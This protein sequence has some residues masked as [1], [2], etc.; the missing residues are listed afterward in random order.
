MPADRVEGV[1]VT[2]TAFDGTDDEIRTSIGACNILGAFT[3]GAVVRKSADG[4][5][6]A[7][8]GNHDAA[9][10]AQC[11]LELRN[12]NV[13][14][15]NA[16]GVG[17]FSTTTILIADGWVRLLVSKAAGVATPR[18]HI[19]KQAAGVWTHEDMTATLSDPATQA[20]GTIRFGEWQDVDDQNGRT[21]VG[22]EWNGVALSDAQVDEFRNARTSDFWNSSAGHPS[23]LWEFSRSPLTDLTGGGAAETVRTGTTLVDDTDQPIWFFDGLGAPHP[24]GRRRGRGRSR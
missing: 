21:A 24:G 10:L 14:A 4:I 3:I 23:G 8:I 13:V 17:V 5:F 9:N 20:G 12:T 6:H 19:F 7:L 18:C 2:V 22:V 1:A 16:S 11:A 15:F